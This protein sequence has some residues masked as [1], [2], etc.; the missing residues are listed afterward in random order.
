MAHGG[1]KDMPDDA[2]PKET[3]A[4]T[5]ARRGSSQWAGT[6]PHNP[7]FRYWGLTS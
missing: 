5:G 7:G 6:S 1:M 4:H 2:A 3:P